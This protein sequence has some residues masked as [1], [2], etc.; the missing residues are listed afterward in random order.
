MAAVAAISVG[1]VQ[2]SVLLD[3]DYSEDSTASVDMNVVMTDSGH[4]VEIQGT[5]EG[6]PFDRAQMNAMVDLA[7]RGISGLL[8]AQRQALEG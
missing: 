4:L 3:L 2:G 1:I 6:R 8:Q 7:E 5:A